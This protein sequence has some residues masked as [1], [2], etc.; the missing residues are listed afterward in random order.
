MHLWTDEETHLIATGRGIARVEGDKATIHRLGQVKA[1]RGNEP[2]DLDYFAATDKKGTTGIFGRSGAPFS[3]AFTDEGVVITPLAVIGLRNVVNVGDKKL[4]VAMPRVDADG[5]MRTI[6]QSATIDEDVVQLGETLTLP[7]PTRVEWPSLIWAKS[8]VPWPE[9]DDEPDPDEPF[10]PGALDVRLADNMWQA[11][12]RLHSNAHGLVVT[13][14]Y[15]G[16][17][18]VFDPKTLKPLFA[19]RIPTQSEVDVR[20]VATKHGV[21]IVVVVEGKE[22][23]ILLVDNAGKVKAHKAKFGKEKAVH[24][25][26]PVLV[27]DDHALVSHGES[28]AYELSLPDL[29]STLCKD[30]GKVHFYG[31]ASARSGKDHIIANG[32][33]G[34]PPN[35]QMLTMVKR[36]KEIECTPRVMPDLREPE[37]LTLPEGPKRVKGNPSL[38]LAAT[39]GGTWRCA[40]N[41]STSI[42]LIVTNVG[43][44]LKGMYVE[45]AGP[46]VATG[47]VEAVDL[48][49]GDT[50][51]P[52]T[53]KGATARAELKTFAIQA[54]YGPPTPVRRGQIDMN[55]Q[56]PKFYMNVGVRGKKAGQGLLTVRIGPT[57]ANTSGSAMQGKTIVIAVPE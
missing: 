17:V 50:E 38:S 42:E 1:S 43:G 21:L 39:A 44:E 54:G 3:F 57:A 25:S 55:P 15:S 45:L 24:L 29:E 22:S 23:G 53:T 2:T 31:S 48:R 13:S 47:I 36:G 37:V 40:P 46:A 4:V 52:F 10:E 32:E 41:G 33:T 34:V 6:L 51:M 7:T 27:G 35:K 19:V 5:R 49:V 26:A 18:A 56:S 9:N 16:M 12:L 14:S 11:Q 8:S 30:L 20:A 28:A